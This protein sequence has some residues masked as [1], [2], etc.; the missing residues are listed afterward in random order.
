MTKDQASWKAAPTEYLKEFLGTDTFRCN[1]SCKTKPKNFPHF[2]WQVMVGWYE[3]K[4]ITE[5]TEKS[6]LETRRECLW[7]NQFI[8]INKQTV[9]WEEWY[10][11]GIKLI[12]DIVDEIGNFLTKEEIEVKYDISCDM[13]MYC[14]LKDAIPPEWRKILKSKEI[15]PNII[16][17][18]DEIIVK[19]GKKGKRLK[20]VTNKELYWV[21]ISKKRENPIF[22]AKLQAELNIAEE[23]WEDI[24][25]IPACI[26]DTKIRV[27]QYKSLFSL[28]PCNLYL[29]RIGKSDTNRCGVCNELDDTA[30][31]LFE[32]PQVVPFWNSFVE[33]WN[34]M[35]NS[36]IFLDKR[37]ALTGFVGPQEIFNT[38]NACLL[39]A[40]W[41]VYK[42]KL[43]ESEVF[44]H[45]Y[46]CDLKYNLDREKIIALRNDNLPRYINRWRIVEDYIT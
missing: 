24:L 14:A 15:N 6:A 35:T 40:K 20:D 42:R 41:H 19:L 26:Y 2:Y 12:N 43:D 4:Q 34:A 31:Y 1:L 28:L 33:W 11:K 13:L 3:V 38:L 5:A 32:C 21:L 27:F 39:M 22:M 10:T 46:L 17:L 44:F 45:N 36:V 18:D 9:K 8:K 23:E 25:I 7:L 30:H 37:S 16:S 29:N